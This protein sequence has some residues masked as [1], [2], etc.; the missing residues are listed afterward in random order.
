MTKLTV[1]LFSLCSWLKISIILV[2]L[3]PVTVGNN[4]SIQC[5][6]PPVSVTPLAEYEGCE[7][8]GGLNGM[9]DAA[10]DIIYDIIGDEYPYNFVAQQVK[11]W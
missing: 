1:S 10:G 4:D 5:N 7:D 6:N 11:L 9:C 2:L 8:R 3:L